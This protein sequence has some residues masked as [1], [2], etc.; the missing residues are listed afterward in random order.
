MQSRSGKTQLLAGCTGT[1]RPPQ[2]VHPL[3]AARVPRTNEIQ[4]QQ[5]TAGVNFIRSP[6]LG[7]PQTFVYINKCRSSM[8]IS[9]RQAVVSRVMSYGRGVSGMGVGG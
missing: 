3:G 6:A 8:Q 1:R 4:L 9:H 2:R 5:Y 7:T